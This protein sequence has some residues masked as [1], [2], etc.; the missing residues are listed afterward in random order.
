M[1]RD[2]ERDERLA[3]LIAAGRAAWPGVA[4][5]EAAFAAHL[6]AHGEAEPQHAADLYLAFGCAR[7]DRAAVAGFLREMVP[8]IEAAV[9][10]LGADPAQVDEVRAQLV[11]ALLVG[12]RPGIATYAGRGQLRSWV[13]SIAVRMGMRQLGRIRARA[14]AGGDEALAALAADADDPEIEHLK[15]LY[16]DAF[17]AAFAAALAALTARQRNLLRQHYL[18]E[19]T[20]DQLGALY[21]VHRATAARWV[22]AAR[23]A[24]FEDTRRR[25]IEALGLAPGDYDSLLRLLHSQLDLSIQRHLTPETGQK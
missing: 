1:G 21:R 20:V 16:G 15:S 6:A 2:P 18:D 8:H 13:R 25:M 14:G 23:E 12:E 17:R 10:G 22:A 9:L 19:L 11:D 24:L 5:D 4:V 3:A 7:G